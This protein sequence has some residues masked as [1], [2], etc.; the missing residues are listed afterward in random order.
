MRS[1]LSSRT[2]SRPERATTDEFFDL[3]AWTTVMIFPSFHSC[4]SMPCAALPE[5]GISRLNACPIFCFFGLQV[6]ERMCGRAD[7][8]GKPFDDLDV[9]VAIH[10]FHLAAVALNLSACAEGRH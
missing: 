7:L 1:P 6:G 10:S 2:N 9:S 4:A 8:A 3:V 5:P